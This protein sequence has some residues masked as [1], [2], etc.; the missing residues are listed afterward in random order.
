MGKYEPLPPVA[1]SLA[2]Y[3]PDLLL[4][5]T[6]LEYIG[7]ESVTGQCG[8]QQKVKGRP[9]SDFVELTAWA[10][11]HFDLMRFYAEWEMK[12]EG[13]GVSNVILELEASFSAGV[14]SEQYLLRQLDE[15]NGYAAIVA[16][17]L[18]FY[19]VHYS[20]VMRNLEKLIAQLEPL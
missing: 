17:A 13:E 7:A 12:D 8:T 10:H 11:R 9:I 16:D 20:R 5:R 15:V 18:T 14:E 3:R 6:L 1:L 4:F 19:R 2:S